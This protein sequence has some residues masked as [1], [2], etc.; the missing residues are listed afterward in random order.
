MLGSPV[1]EAFTL[2]MYSC[3]VLK[4][5]RTFWDELCQCSDE[6]VRHDNDVLSNHV[7]IVETNP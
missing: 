7:E 3:S 2:N 4:P 6:Q 5:S 1:P